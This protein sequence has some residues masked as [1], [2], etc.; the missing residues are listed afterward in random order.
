MEIERLQ[1]GK[2]RQTAQTGGGT[3][4]NESGR[5]STD[6]W[7][8]EQRIVSHIGRSVGMLSPGATIERSPRMWK[9]RR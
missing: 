8:P 9:S 7:L 2:L 6:T 3:Q 1:L 4:R 5:T